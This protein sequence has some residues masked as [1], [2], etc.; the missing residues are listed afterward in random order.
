MLNAIDKID[1]NSA[2]I[3]LEGEMVAGSIDELREKMKKKINNG[4]RAVI[5]DM[6]EVKTIDS[7][8]IG[9]LAASHNSLTKVGGTLSVIGLSEEMYKFFIG[10][11]LNS[12][13]KIDKI[14]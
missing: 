14:N 8:G 9:F 1:E 2:L 4:I 13:F 5:M 11:R 10:L 7:T 12:H 6:T 3:K